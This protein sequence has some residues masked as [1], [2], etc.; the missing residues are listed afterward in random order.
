MEG[1][2]LHV[3]HI[4]DVGGED[5]AAIGSDFDGMLPQQA[6]NRARACPYYCAELPK[7]SVRA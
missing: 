4:I 6:W 2:L 5:C 7:N 1:A 3:A